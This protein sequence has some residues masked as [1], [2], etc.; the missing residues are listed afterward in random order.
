MLYVPQV[1]IKDKV[2]E[3]LMYFTKHSDE[4][5]QTKAII[6]LGKLS[7]SFSVVCSSLRGGVSFADCE[8]ELL[9]C[10]DMT[11]SAICCGERNIRTQQQLSPPSPVC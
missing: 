1:N 3:L 6:G 8:S 5:V 9:V 4:E 2:L 10:L 11:P 7:L